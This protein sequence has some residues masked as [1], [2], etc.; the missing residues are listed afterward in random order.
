MPEPEGHENCC[1]DAGLGMRPEQARG[2]LGLQGSPNCWHETDLGMPPA[3]WSRHLKEPGWSVGEQMHC[4]MASFVIGG[5]FAA[6]ATPI[7]EAILY[8]ATA[9]LRGLPWLWPKLKAESANE[10]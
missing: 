7:F 10:F 8:A 2:E 6:A 1:C 5:T 9:T 4:R 3:R